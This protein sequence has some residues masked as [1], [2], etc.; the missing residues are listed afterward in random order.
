LKLWKEYNVVMANGQ[1][2]RSRSVVARA[3]AGSVGFTFLMWT[4]GHR[5][6]RRRLA[7]G[8]RSVPSPTQD[9]QMARFNP[10]KWIAQLMRCERM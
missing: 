5:C 6:H 3:Q 7:G 10:D 9:Y 8:C 1:I 4:S 2:W